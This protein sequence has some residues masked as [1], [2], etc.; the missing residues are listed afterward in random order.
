MTVPTRLLA[1]KLL[2]KQ[3]CRN[4]IWQDERDYIDDLLLTARNDKAPPE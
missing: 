1:P 3:V 2:L 4:I